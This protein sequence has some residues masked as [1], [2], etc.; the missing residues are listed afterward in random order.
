MIIWG[1]SVEYTSGTV[2]NALTSRSSPPLFYPN[3]T[4]KAF[5]IAQLTIKQQ[6]LALTTAIMASSMAFID[7][8]ALTVA[9]PA[10]QRSL[11]LDGSQLLWVVNAYTLFLASLMLLGGSLGDLFGKRQVF[12]IGIALFTVF[13][14]LCG[15][16]QSGPALIIGRALQ[17][18]GGALMVPGSL[19]LITATFPKQK[20][21]SAIGTWSMLSAFTTI[22]G[23][24]VGGYLA[25]EGLWRA[26]FLIN[27]P[28]GVA[29]FLIL[30]LKVPEPVRTLGKRLDWQGGLLA[31]LA[32]GGITYGFIEASEKGFD[33]WY[34]WLAIGLG[35]LALLL[36]IVI[37]AR[38]PKPMMPLALFRSATFSG[39]NALTL[40]VYG[41]LGAILF[42][43]PLNLIQIQGYPEHLAGFAILPFG[44]TIALLARFSGRWTDRVGRK[45]PLIA[46]PLVTG[47]AFLF[48]CPCGP[49]RWSRAVLEQ[50]FST[51]VA[52]W[53]RHGHHCSATYHHGNELRCR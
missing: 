6:N 2:I 16:A 7:S 20:R 33:Q 34:L 9:L 25:G 36:F 8:T 38:S 39:A 48:I 51:L 15:L 49:Y 28:L 32:F 24:V 41:A 29:S 4:A 30:W 18:A 43:V 11:G 40:F 46:G 42:F 22:L 14:A 21:G 44:A 26:I 52:G 5:V 23:P 1:F 37:E 31:T 19:A 3:F 50:L 10:L 45:T 12:M 13:S 47:A 27:L 35:T 17:G 53:Y